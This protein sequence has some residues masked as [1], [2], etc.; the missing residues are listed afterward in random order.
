MKPNE[1]MQ[2]LKEAAASND[3]VIDIKLGKDDNNWVVIRVD[4]VQKDATI[5]SIVK[6]GV[7]IQ[8]SEKEK[9]EMLGFLLLA[10]CLEAYE[11]GLKEEDRKRLSEIVTIF[12]IKAR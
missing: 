7:E 3:P 9:K 4:R 1:L 8:M 10:I 6:D 2:T 5:T 11:N 12:D